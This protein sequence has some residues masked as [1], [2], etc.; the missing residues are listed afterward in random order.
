M[1]EPIAADIV[2]DVLFTMTS[3]Y[4]PGK[5]GKAANRPPH[6]FGGTLYGAV[7]TGVPTLMD[8][9]LPTAVATEL[10]IG[11]SIAPRFV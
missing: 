11:R 9:L 3:F 1:I 5:W 2:V 6:R 7:T 8:L 10:T 4:Q